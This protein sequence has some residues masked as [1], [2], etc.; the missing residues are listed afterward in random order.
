M[1]GRYGGSDD[2]SSD[3][4]DRRPDWGERTR[5]SEQRTVAEAV[6]S[7]MQRQQGETDANEGSSRS[8]P[9]VRPNVDQLVSTT[10]D[11]GDSV[12]DVIAGN[13]TDIIRRANEAPLPDDESY[14]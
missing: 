10:T 5:E 11:A 2:G 3:Y 6:R 13:L 4:Q 1:G 12:A 9:Q 14:K 7:V 8:R